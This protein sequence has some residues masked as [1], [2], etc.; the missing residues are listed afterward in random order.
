MSPRCSVMCLFCGSSLVVC[1]LVWSPRQCNIAATSAA[2]FAKTPSC[3]IG[4]ILQINGVPV[5]GPVTLDAQGGF[6]TTFPAPAT[7]GTYVIRTDYTPTGS[8]DRTICTPAEVSMSNTVCQSW[9]RLSLFPPV[10]ASQ[11]PGAHAMDDA[12]CKSSGPALFVT[13]FMPRHRG[14]LRPA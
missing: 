3:T 8:V 9:C 14:F 12:V 11:Q 13:C 5:G 7:P 1:A 4:C 6:T 10:M 2:C